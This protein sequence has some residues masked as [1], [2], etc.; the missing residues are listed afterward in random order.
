MPTL[1]VLD[2]ELATH[3]VAMATLAPS[4]HNT[5]PWHFVR[6]GDA[7]D[8]RA[9]RSRQLSVLDPDGRQLVQSC[10]A[11]LHHLRV[12]TRAAGRDLVVELLP[13]P[14][15]RDLLARVT[16]TMGPTASGSEV[17]E[18]VDE[19]HRGTVRG[20]FDDG[21]LPVGLV[22]RLADDAALEGVRLR[23]VRPEELPEVQVLVSR[24]EQYLEG[25]PAYLAEL[26][27]WVHEPT[28]ER[29]D[30]IPV[31]A[32]EVT[33]DRGELVAGRAFVPAAEH[34]T[35][36]PAA[37]HPTLVLLLTA[38]DSPRDWLAAGQALSRLLLRCTHEGVGAQPIGQV[39]DVPATRIG[40]QR[41]LGVVGVPQLVLRLGPATPVRRTVRHEVSDVLDL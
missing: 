1:T 34:S 39:I 33:A 17:S 30:G 7:L 16:V 2:D 14:T 10:G 26:G 29:P 4:V 8:L 9:D 25:D 3:L 38:S 27:R 36:P 31:A 19:L 21:P 22:D 5:Q 24:A 20:R 12:A 23:T 6:R 18:A 15:D 35:E 11:A 41:A 32:L 28:D 13:E 40:L 37:E